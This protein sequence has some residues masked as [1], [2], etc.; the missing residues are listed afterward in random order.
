MF[1]LNWA[2]LAVSVF[3]TILLLWL[4]LTVLLNAE[5][6]S[7][8]LVLA[9][10]GLL[11]G[12]AFFLAHSAILGL[13]LLEQDFPGGLW[14]AVGW[15]PLV[16]L[17]YAWYAAMLWYASFWEDRTSAMHRRH[18]RGL[19]LAS[20]LALV[21]VILLL[22][23]NPLPPFSV[24]NLTPWL[25]IGG[26]PLLVLVFPLYLLTCIGLALDGLLRPGQPHR[27]MGSLARRRARPWLLAAT[28]L[29]L[30]I[31]LL[32]GGAMVWIIQTARSQDYTHAAAILGAFDVSTALLISGVVLLLGQAIISYE[33]FTGKTLPSRGLQRYW[34]R[35]IILAAGFGVT[36]SWAVAQRYPPV[37]IL[38]LS[39]VLMT[40][41]YALLAW[42][43]FLDRERHLENLRPF[44]TGP[45]LYDQL[46]QPST[47]DWNAA[48][49]LQALCADLLNAR[50]AYLL[51]MGALAPLMGPGLAYPD[52]IIPSLPGLSELEQRANTP[53]QICLP[54]EAEQFAGAAWAIPLWSERGRIGLLLLGEKRDQSLYAQEEFE[55]ARSVAER[56]ID[57]LASAELARRLMAL[58]RQR[59]A[60]SQ[61]LDQR[62]RRTLHD[63]ILPRLHAVLLALNTDPQGNA[64][65]IQSLSQ[66]H[67]QVSA[68]LHDLPTVSAPQVARLG[69][70]HALRQAVEDEYASAFDQLE[71]E[72]SPAAMEEAR[73]I[74]PLAAEVLYYAAREAVRNA[75][76]HARGPLNDG[77]SAPLLC[78][79][80]SAAVKDGLLLTIEDNGVGFA[81][82]PADPAQVTGAGQGLALHS[83][84]MAVIGG[85]LSVESVPGQFTRVAL[86]LNI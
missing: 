3:N 29:L 32:V 70:F 11:M 38:L 45:L 40:I 47:P 78:L 64:E 9:G 61:V 51:P 49:P 24:I 83:T 86:S 48:Q 30:A 6:R 63:D 27:I 18:R 20:L 81:S 80:I 23:A 17:P 25:S 33:I 44:V 16:G 36:V 2:I 39:T 15:V 7:W 14:W 73:Q 13:G 37:Y 77:E 69:L 75:A 41:F 79:R 82:P 19:I 60:E 35:S 72:I 57:T 28:G 21:I 52:G 65:A 31:S 43:S 22:I 42:R 59:L 55:I 4:G 1:Y 84:L 56:L 58:Q 74:P 34:R 46:V 62:T 53:D 54:L 66:A 71:W 12:G 68:L 76:R 5:R 8:G 85:T 26:M 50:L 10:G 67:R